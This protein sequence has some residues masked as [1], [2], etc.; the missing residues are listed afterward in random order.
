MIAGGS[1]LLG[2]I[3]LSEF[4]TENNTFDF[5]DFRNTIRIA[6]I[7]LNSV[8]DEGLPL[9]PLEEQKESV[10]DWRQIGLTYWVN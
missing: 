6:V 3:N 5:Y 1:C 7:A 2:S 9:H 4:V 10:R 8:L